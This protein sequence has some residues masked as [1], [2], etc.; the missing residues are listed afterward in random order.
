MPVKLLLFLASSLL[1]AAMM[2]EISNVDPR[3]AA[4]GEIMDAH[5]SKMLLKDGIYHWFAASYSNCTEP[6][7][8]SGCAA[9]PGQ[10]GFLY[11][12]NVSLFTSRDLVTW[13]DPV[14]DFSATEL[15]VPG[16]IMY[17]P[18]VVYNAATSKFVLWFNWLT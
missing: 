2:V 13:S 15:G 6:T 11:N 17:A 16:A 9:G 10:C 18:K 7:G 3:R 12:H 4:S 8:N 14:V 1:G 5:D